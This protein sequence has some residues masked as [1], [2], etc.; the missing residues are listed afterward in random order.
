MKKVLESVVEVSSVHTIY[1]LNL[2]KDYVFVG[3][4]HPFYEINIILEGTLGLTIGDKLYELKKGQA[5]I[6]P[7]GEFHKD[8]VV[9]NK[10]V[11]LFVVTFDMHSATAS[12]K[13]GAVYNIL[14]EDMFYVETILAEGF[15]WIRDKVK[16]P[17]V[18]VGQIIKNS[19]ESLIISMLRQSP[20]SSVF[21]SSSG[22]IFY[23][24]IHFMNMN[25]KKNV[26]MEELAEFANTSVAN[27]KKVFK[28]Y[29]GSGAIHHFNMLK[30][31]YSKELL[32]L[33]TPISEI[34]FMLSYSS[35]NHFAQSF[36][37]TFGVTPTEF[38]KEMF[39]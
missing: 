22:E 26:T 33:D 14:Q 29:T 19:I 27:L 5:C 23:K 16:N 9:G 2:Q 30:L 4:S 37:K 25:I 31:E 1:D 8:W 21:V 6:I 13:T 32:R 15:N 24:A 38:K 36:K 17:E 20:E 28:K 39:N 7:A 10:P 18:G 12:F 11:R 35:Q 34:S 3:E